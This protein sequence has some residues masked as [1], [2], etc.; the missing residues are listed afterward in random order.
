MYVGYSTKYNKWR[1]ECDLE[2]INEAD[3]SEE[4]ECD[5]FSY[6][7]FSLHSYMKVKIT[8]LYQ[9]KLTFSENSCAV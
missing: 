7:P 6:E 9:E 4:T 1:D 3:S 2:P 8:V 5:G